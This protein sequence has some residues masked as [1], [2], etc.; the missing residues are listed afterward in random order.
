[1]GMIDKKAFDAELG[2]ANL[3]ETVALCVREVDRIYRES[4]TIGGRKWAF[5]QL[6][7]GVDL[8]AKGLI[9]PRAP[10]VDRAAYAHDV[11][12]A[13]V[14]LA[15]QGVALDRVKAMAVLALVRL[16]A[17]DSGAY[18]EQSRDTVIR[19]LDAS[20]GDR[21]GIVSVDRF[22]S[23]AEQLL[24]GRSYLDRI[25]GL[26]ALTGRRTFEVG[27]S[28]TFTAMGRNRV[29]FAGQAKTRD[30]ENGDSAYSIPVLTDNA[31]KVVDTLATI[32]ADKPDLT[33]LSSE[34]FHNRCA[35]DLH[36]RAQVFS[37]VFSDNV[38]K[39]KDLRP[40]YAE[41]AWLLVDERR[42]GKAL[43]LARVLGHGDR[44]L[45]TAQSYDDFVILDPEYQ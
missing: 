6:R 1:M 14:R 28:A 43:F 38:A 21:R 3:L 26:C 40:A 11:T 15:G 41:I 18:R 12:T 24:E 8:S 22:V 27:C 30:R 2:K 45:L 17:L 39:P 44:D 37:E 25:L 33:G 10:M 5:S 34:Q 19:D 42:T 29:N 31:T 9:P 16:D 20:H 35:K 36:K 7:Q 32:R 23:I 13:M 4:V